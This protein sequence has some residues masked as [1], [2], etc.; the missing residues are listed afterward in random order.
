MLM[1]I[2]VMFFKNDKSHLRVR[3]RPLPWALGKAPS[4]R[5]AEL[6]WC[7]RNA[8]PGSR[9]VHGAPQAAAPMGPCVSGQS[10]LGHRRLCSPP[11]EGVLV[12][13]ERC[14]VPAL[15]AVRLGW[16]MFPLLIG[17]SYSPVKHSVPHSSEQREGRV[18]CG[19]DFGQARSSSIL[20]HVAGTETPV[21]YFSHSLEKKNRLLAGVTTAPSL[22]LPWQRE[23]GFLAAW[24]SPAPA[25]LPALLTV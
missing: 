10:L 22:G 3:V 2:Q 11:E 7:R 16:E 12:R 5:G 8:A 21:H 23:S 19:E 18:H 6:P 15:T 13:P 1:Q 25:G 20:D 14:G 4:S 24:F 9:A 17:S